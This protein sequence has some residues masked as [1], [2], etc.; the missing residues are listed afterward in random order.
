MCKGTQ[1]AH[2]KD[3]AVEWLEFPYDKW[4]FDTVALY[5]EGD[6]GREGAEPAAWLVRVEGRSAAGTITGG[7]GHDQAMIR[8]KDDLGRV[9]DM[10]D[11]EANDA[12]WCQRCTDGHKCKL[13]NRQVPHMA[14]GVCVPCRWKEDGYISRS[15]RATGPVLPPPLRDEP[16]LI[17]VGAFDNAT[18]ALREITAS[19]TSTI[20]IN[21]SDFS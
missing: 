10:S 13:C 2:D 17:A 4:K 20:T 9:A 6:W 12:G 21:L 18:A 19:L 15:S 7:P 11:E 14:M 8:L 16:P 1:C 5:E 3:S